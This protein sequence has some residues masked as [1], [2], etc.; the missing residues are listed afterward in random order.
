MYMARPLS[1]STRIPS[2]IVTTAAY[3]PLGTRTSYFRPNF[4]IYIPDRRYYDQS[5]YSLAKSSDIAPTVYIGLAGTVAEL[6]LKLDDGTDK[7]KLS[8][9]ESYDFG[10]AGYKRRREHCRILETGDGFGLGSIVESHRVPILREQRY[11]RGHRFLPLADR[12]RHRLDEWFQV[13]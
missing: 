6:N 13:A 11:N 12:R 9:P 10:L 7:H 1:V 2:L 4:N 8:V 3:H 5:V